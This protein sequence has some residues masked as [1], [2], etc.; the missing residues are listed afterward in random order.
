MKPVAM[1]MRK[2]LFGTCPERRGAD[3]LT[4]A[5][6]PHARG[7]RAVAKRENAAMDEREA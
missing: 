2:S 3:A 7:S 1:L 5:T 4:C 6:L